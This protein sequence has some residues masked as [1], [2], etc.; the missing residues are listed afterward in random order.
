MK[1]L[2][3]ILAAILIFALAACSGGNSASTDNNGN[4][5]DSG[6]SGDS[7]GTTNISFWGPFS[8]PDGPNMKKIVDAYNK[9]QDKVH[10]DFQIVPFTDYYKKVDLA[11]NSGKTPDVLIIHG[12]QLTKY[13]QKDLLKNLNDFVGDKIKKSD[14][15]QTAIEQ[16][17]FDGNLYAIPLDIHPLMMYWNKDMFKAAGLDPN[18]PPQT[19]EEFL[20]VTQKLTDASKG[21][22]GYV[23]PTLWPQQF[24]FPTIVYQNGG[25]MLKD[26][27][28]DYTS[29]AVVNAL[30]FEHDLIYK[31]KVSPPNVQQDGEVTLFL[32][33]KNAI[34]FNGPWMLNQFKEAGL[35]FGEAPVPQ[36]GTEQ[37]AVFTD[38]HNFAIPKSDDEETVT[39]VMDFLK[40]VGG[41]GMSWAKSGQAPAAKA[42]YQ[43]EEF[44]SLKYQPAIVKE[45]EYAQFAPKDPNWGTYTTPLWD[46]VNKVLLD[47]AD[48]MEALKKAEEQANKAAQ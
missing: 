43:S 32:Q 12:N 46:A 33:G 9:S 22:Y 19:R 30:K 11:F 39:A 8:G 29:D 48:A 5:G 18:K 37:Q 16:D 35:N 15:N 6:S 3:L 7:G 40:Y 24:I 47:K 21:Q 20:K 2:G 14:Y 34:Q 25:K 31:Y 28:V 44:Q 27:K 41:H 45:F 26:G 10:V 36:L 1:G 42:T 13:V 23:V 4:S 17:T 38:G